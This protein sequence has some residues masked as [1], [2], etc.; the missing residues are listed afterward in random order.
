MITVIN[1][2]LSLTWV[3]DVADA[4]NGNKTAIGL[5]SLAVYVLQIVPVVFPQFGV[6]LEIAA[7]LQQVLLYIG[8]TLTPIGL[9]HKV[10]KVIEEKQNGK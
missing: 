9:A 2:L 4:I 3:G 6:A 8:V 10:G 7:N 1:K 5:I